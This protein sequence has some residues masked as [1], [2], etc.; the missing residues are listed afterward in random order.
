M[1]AGAVIVFLG[2][3]GGDRASTK[4]VNQL[5][6]QLHLTAKKVPAATLKTLTHHGEHSKELVQEMH[7]AGAVGFE[8][9]PGHMLRVVVYDGRGTMKTFLE[10]GFDEL[11]T[12]RDNISSDVEDLGGAAPAPEPAPKPLPA[13]KADAEPAIEMD[14]APEPASRPARKPVKAAPAPADDADPTDSPVPTADAAPSDGDGVDISEVESMTASASA[15]APTP[16][17]EQALHLGASVGFGIAGR[18]FA[19]PAT[20]PGYASSPVGTVAGEAHVE[21]S[22]H[23]T[24]AVAGERT[25]S[26]TTPLHDGAAPTTMAHWHATARYAIVDGKVRVAPTVGLGRRTFVIQSTDPSR[27]PDGDYTYA[28]LGM[29]TAVTIT[30]RATFHAVAALEPV[31]GGTDATQMAFG[32]ATRWGALGGVALVTK[33]TSH[34]VARAAADYQRFSWSWDMAGARGAG[35][36]VDSYLSASITVG[37]AY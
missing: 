26:M 11:D 6:H 32:P 36:A 37:A 9:V 16:R 27:S 28:S 15:D 20:L 30:P 1:P 3:L 12:L 19:G 18:S 34:V 17:V 8:V 7:V 22:A 2:L 31:I 29:T 23:V 25:L 21:P 35:G 24:L 14:A 10:T 5:A 13:P 4:Q 33:L